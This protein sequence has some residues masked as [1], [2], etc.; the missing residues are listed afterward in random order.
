MPNYPPFLYRVVL[1]LGLMVVVALV[2]FYRNCLH[3]TKF[4]EYSFVIIAG[5]IGAVV[6]LVNDL[7]TSSI[8]PE[9]FIFGKGL[10]DGP[11]LRIQAGLFGLQVGF[12]AGVIA[13]AISL[14]ITR[15][16]SAYPPVKCSRLLRMLWMPVAGAVLC[17]VII[18]LLFSK[19]DPADFSDQ[20]KG[21]LDAGKLNRFRQVW[22]TH[23][24]LYAGMIIG[25]AAML[26]RA[27]RERKTFAAGS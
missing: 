19:F 4:R 17:G 14:Y 23:M 3:A 27:V 25:L 1:L 5:G 18:P 10:E 13:G 12:S 16:K 2:D 7:I 20:L 15:R 9:Y 26:L 6:G 24:G 11:N 21:L 22:W 8:S